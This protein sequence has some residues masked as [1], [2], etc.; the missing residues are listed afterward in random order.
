MTTR[1]AV[2]DYVWNDAFGAGC[3]YVCNAVHGAGFDYARNAVG[4]D[5]AR[6]ATRDAV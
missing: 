5:Y 1:D 2:C 6:G 4:W 3:G